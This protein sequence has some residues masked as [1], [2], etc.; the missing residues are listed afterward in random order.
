MGRARLACC[1]LLMHAADSAQLIV[2]NSLHTML[3]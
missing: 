2:L 1:E 3:S